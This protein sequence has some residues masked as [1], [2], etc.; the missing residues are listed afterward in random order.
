SVLELP[1]GHGFEVQLAEVSA[2]DPLL[3]R[4]QLRAVAAEV[5]AEVPVRVLLEPLERAGE[6]ALRAREVAVGEMV[7]GHRDLDEALEEVAGGPAQPGPHLLQG[8]VALEEVAGVE[9]CHALLEGAPLLG[10]EQGSRRRA[11]HAAMMARRPL[12]SSR[13]P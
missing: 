12:L 5:E 3:P 11:G 1:L 2:L 4:A 8:V 7:E 9:L 6:H 10:V 13:L